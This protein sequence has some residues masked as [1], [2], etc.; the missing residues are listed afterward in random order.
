M[1]INHSGFLLLVLIAGFFGFFVSFPAGA[2]GQ[3]LEELRLGQHFDRKALYQAGPQ[4]LDEALAGKESSIALLGMYFRNGERGFPKNVAVANRLAS[5]AYQKGHWL[6]AMDLAKEA[7]EQGNYRSALRFYMIV[8]LTADETDYARVKRKPYTYQ[9]AP[10]ITHEAYAKI[11]ILAQ[12]EKISKSD[13]ATIEA[14]ARKEAI[15]RG[16]FHDCAGA[17]ERLCGSIKEEHE[18]DRIETILNCRATA[19]DLCLKRVK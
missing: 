13:M 7:A 8:F 16:F 14:A 9:R 10:N 1:R 4:V 17:A 6:S 19:E 18:R 3:I 15:E 2:E 5:L 11:R 12:S